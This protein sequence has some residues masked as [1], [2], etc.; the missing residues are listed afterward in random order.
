MSAARSG[1]QVITTNERDFA[2][3]AEFRAFEWQV[4]TL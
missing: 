2:R 3:L 4:A 1:I